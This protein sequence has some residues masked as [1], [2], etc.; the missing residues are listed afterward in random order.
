MLNVTDNNYRQSVIGNAGNVTLN[1]YENC[2][3]RQLP[4]SNVFACVK[5]RCHSADKHV[6]LVV[7]NGFALKHGVVCKCICRLMTGIVKILLST[8]RTF[9]TLLKLTKY[10]HRNFIKVQ[11]VENTALLSLGLELKTLVSVVR[12]RPRPPYI[13]IKRLFG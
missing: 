2:S 8:V 4:R 3:H 13:S 10:A 12:F 11:H 9:T 1:A 7:I 5:L 6:K